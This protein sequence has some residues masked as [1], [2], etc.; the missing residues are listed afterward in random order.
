MGGQATEHNH[1]FH[2]D[3]IINFSVNKAVSI[4]FRNHFDNDVRP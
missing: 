4:N 2:F 3:F 1:A